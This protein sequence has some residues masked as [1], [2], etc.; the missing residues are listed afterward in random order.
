MKYRPEIDGMRAVAVI[1]VLLFH[2]E[3]SWCPG[4]F[5]GVD[6]FFVISGYLIT[7]IIRKDVAAGKFSLLNFYERRARRILPAFVVMLT[8]VLAVSLFVVLPSAFKG[9]GRSVTSSALSVSNI[10]FWAEDGY[11]AAASEEK[12]LLHTWSLGVEE[13]FY[14]LLPLLMM[15]ISSNRRCVKVIAICG[16]TS[17]VFSVWQVRYYPSAAFFLLPARAWELLLGSV[18]ATVSVEAVSSRVRNSMALCGLLTILYGACAYTVSTVFPGENALLPCLGAAAIIVGSSEGLTSRLL[19]WRPVVFVGRISYSL[20]LWHWPVL[21]LVQ[22]WNI[23][24]LNTTQTI[25]CLVASFGIAVLS[26]RFVEQPFRSKRLVGSCR[27]ML[28]LSVTALAVFAIAGSYVHFS[29][30][31]PQRFPK[32]VVR[33]DG[34]DRDEY[35]IL[36]INKELKWGG[37]NGEIY[38]GARVA[39]RIAVLGDSHAPAIGMALGRVAHHR[40]ESVQLFSQNGVSPL[41]GVRFRSSND[42]H[43]RVDAMLKQIVEQESI[44]YVVV[45]GRWGS[46][47]H[48]F[49]TDFGTFERGR[50][51]APAIKE[52]INGKADSDDEMVELFSF[53]IN[54]TVDRLTKAGKRV[55]IVYSVPEVGYHVP[56]TMARLLNRGDDISQFTRPADY[57]FRRQQH[58]LHAFDSLSD[59]KVNRVFPHKLLIKGDEAIVQENGIPLY[60]DD[61]HLSLAG[62]TKLMPLFEPT[63]WPSDRDE[64]ALSVADSESSDVEVNRIR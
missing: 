4:G 35:A 39:P 44:E 51:D 41:A 3:G 54:E 32:R 31:V 17:L 47:L 26:W 48:G 27:Q 8:T 61:D 10:L 15:W 49:N 14:F 63:L 25:A 20:Y 22:Q 46:V 38:Y 12:P 18:L 42:A 58:V 43:E 28:S 21:I 50:S 23:F 53:A 19:S 1:L 62:A 45:V 16:I 6:V 33:L 36:K 34:G 56:R 57:Y 40:H 11:F 55:V 24:P 7:S 30:G 59:A 9:V 60:C 13:Q 2:A 5:I 64:T 37:K 52:R 29:N